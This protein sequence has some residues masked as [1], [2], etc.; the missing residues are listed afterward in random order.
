MRD[1]LEP[2]DGPGVVDMRE[3]RYVDCSVLGELAR[4]AR[5]AGAGNVTLVVASRHVRRIL[6]LVEFERLFVIAD[7]FPKR[8]LRK[9]RN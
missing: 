9:G 2:L 8:V 6:E 7:G 5:R 1:A 3:V 4:V